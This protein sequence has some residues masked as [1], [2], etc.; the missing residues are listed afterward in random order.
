MTKEKASL[1]VIDDDVDVL[2][3]ARIF[4]KQ[5][6]TTVNTIADPTEIN[7]QV[8][9]QAFDVILL[10]MNFRKGTNDGK[11]GLYWM[12]RILEIN[13]S[14]IIVLMTAYGDVELAVEAIKKGATDFILKPWNNERLLKTISSA[15]DLSRAKR[16][17]G[18][19]EKQEPV[20]TLS[21]KSNTFIGKSPSIKELF[22][23]I[24]KVGYTDANVLITG[25]NGTGKE[26]IANEIH[27]RSKRKDEV[28]VR[29]DLGSLNENLFESELF[30]HVKGAFTDARQDKPGRFEMADG[31]TIFLDEIGN[32]T[33]TMQSKLLTV[34]QNQK[35]TRVGSNKEI[36]INARLICATNANLQEMVEEGSF[37]EDLLYRINTVEL[38][39]PALR[40]RMGDIELLVHFFLNLYSKKYGKLGLKVS[41]EGLRALEK[42]RWP[43]NVRELQHAVERAVILSNEP[44][45]EPEDFPLSQKKKNAQNI[46][47]VVRLDEMEKQM[48]ELAL[49]RNRGNIS[50]ASKDLG[51]TRAALYRRMEKHGL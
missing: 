1:L 38:H 39:L 35:V 14:A 46:T 51:I 33:P 32:L 20:S 41:K 13:P 3:S 16:E 10:D 47:E 28:F 31:G 43:G 17:G 19:G 5:W 7:Q 22:Q 26:L 24:D 40:E 2:T 30:G 4:L 45:L 18:T 27:Q 48:V 36:S 23:V 29:V 12:N 37:R 8:T 49:Q 25:E 9:Q 15:V 34:L 50:R 6:F 42:Y 11:E 21:Q 44:V